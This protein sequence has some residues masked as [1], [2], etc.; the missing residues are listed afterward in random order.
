MVVATMGLCRHNSDSK[1]SH[2]LKQ[3]EKFRLIATAV[4]ASTEMAAAIAVAAVAVS[5]RTKLA[6]Y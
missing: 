5:T 1:S 4:K 2:R 3:Q 6:Y